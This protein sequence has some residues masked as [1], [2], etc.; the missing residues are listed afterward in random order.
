MPRIQ[1]KRGTS[2]NLASVNPTPLA[3]ELVW[4]STENAI[5]IGDGATAWTS[6]AYVTAT[7]RSH[8]HDGGEIT[9]GTVAY[10]RLPV[11]S[12]TSTVCA[13]DD[14]RLSDARSPTAHKSS[15][16]TGG[17][18]A[19]TP[20]DI[21]AAPAA[22]P[23]IT[24]NATFEA[25]SGV[26][27]TV[28]N[29]GTGNSFVVNDAS[30]DTTPFVVDASGRVGIGTSSPGY[31]LDVAGG[32]R[33]R[34]GTQDQMV[35]GA[36]NSGTSITD[37]VLKIGGL[38]VPH[39][40][41]D[42]KNVGVILGAST[43]TDN[44]IEIG[45]NSGTLN[46]ATSI[47]FY[48]AATTTSGIGPRRM[49]IDGSGN[50]GIGTSTTSP[51]SR[52]DVNGVITVSATAGSAG[53]Y[54][55][56]LTISGD[57]NTGFGQVSGQ[58]DTASIFTAGNERVRVRAD[59]NVGLAS[60]GVAHIGLLVQNTLNSTDARSAIFCQPKL[61]SSFTSDFTGVTSG[62]ELQT[63]AAI[64]NAYTFLAR[65]ATIASGA[66]VTNQYGLVVPASFTAGT[67]NY[68]IL[69]GIPSGSNRWNIY[70][71]GTADNYL[72]GDCGIKTDDPTSAL[73]INSDKIRLRTAKTPASASDTG[74]A[75]DI[76][77]DASYLYICTATNTWRRIAHST[78]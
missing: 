7:P 27:L 70:A 28:T 32:F 19:L 77:W 23:A 52:L 57:A 37:G 30:G 43:S 55:P 31:P 10:A 64:T 58:S 72:N 53:S 13:G 22:S 33:F 61:T 20:G 69:L 6:L 12:T 3:G 2:A 73:D 50:V 4:D 66:S 24:G 11:G 1:H 68:A 44:I 36:D 48:T 15:H 45:G 65:N 74:N 59:G 8:V 14:A 5:K 63:N 38:S 54:L 62:V 46:S 78:W 67:N 25:S 35:I 40:N 75:G 49:V 34:S 51:A 60:A 21:G 29:T 17:S 47:R 26:P 71:S 42:Q 39:F 76:C 41:T 18:D 56:S 16:A 9:T